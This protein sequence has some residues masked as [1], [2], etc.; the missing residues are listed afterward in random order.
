[1]A[2][3]ECTNVSDAN[4]C[5]RRYANDVSGQVNP[6]ESY[7][8][9]R[10]KWIAIANA[11]GKSESHAKS[12]FTKKK[13]ITKYKEETKKD[14]F[15]KKTVVKTP[16][17]YDYEYTFPW[18]LACAEFNAEIPEEAYIKRVTFRAKMRVTNKDAKVSKPIGNF[19]FRRFQTVEIKEETGG[20]KTGWHNGSYYVVDTNEKL[21]HTW[22]EHT[23][24]INEEDLQLAKITHENINSVFC[25]IDFI[26][27]KAEFNGDNGETEVR[28][29][30]IRMKVEY[31]MPNYE[32]GVYD[33]VHKVHENTDKTPTKIQ[34]DKQFIVYIFAHNRTKAKG[35]TQKVKVD[36]PW[37][38]EIDGVATNWG[39]FDPVTNIWTF[40]K[41]IDNGNNDTN[42]SLTFRLRSKKIGLSNLSAQYQSNG[43]GIN[44]WWDIDTTIRNSAYTQTT[45]TAVNTKDGFRRNSTCCVKVDIHVVSSDN[46]IDVH[47]ASTPY[48]QNTGTWSLDP[49]NSSPEVELTG[50]DD[51][52]SLN[53]AHLVYNGDPVESDVYEYN[54]SL[55]FCF[56]PNFVG[57]LTL[58]VMNSEEFETTYAYFDVLEALPF[59]VE[60][61]RI[62][63]VYKINNHRLFSEVEI[64][65]TIIRCVSD[66]IDK[67]MIMSNCS[68]SA[69]IWEDLD[70]IGCIPLEHLHFDPK[71]TYK[72]TL[73]NSTYKNKRYMGKKLA[74]DEDITL[75]VRLHPQQVT[76]LQGLIDMDKPIP[77]N[78]NHKCFEGDSLNH[79]GWAEVYAVKTEQTG[80][81]PHWYKCDIDVK[82]LTHN[83]NTRFKIDKSAKV[84]DYDS[85]I[86]S[87]MTESWSSGSNLS[88]DM[89]DSLG[90]ADT[91]KIPNNEA[92]FETDTDGTFHYVD[93]FYIDDELV[94]IDDD[95]RNNFN[96]DNGQH[97]RVTT[98]NPLTHISDVSFTWSS[99]LIDEIKENDISRIIRLKDKDNKVYF[100]YQYDNIIID[101][102]EISA[103]IIY[104]V[105]EEND[106]MMDYEPSNRMRFRY[107]PTDS[108]HEDDDIE[109]EPDDEAIDETGEAH[110]G[111][112]VELSLKNN[113][114][115][116]VDKG[117][118]GREVTISAELTDAEYYYEVEWVNNN[119]DAET[120][121]IECSFDFTVKDTILTSTYASKF[122][123]LVV[124]PYPI[125]GKK[126][127][128][129][130]EAQEGTI[131]YYED[132]RKEFSYLIEPY[133]QY[134]N[135]TDLVTNDGVS[136][137][138]LNYGY[139]IVYIQNGLVRLGFNRLNGELYLGKYDPQTDDYITT[140][141]L[142]LDKFDDINLN[143]ISD[144]KIEIQSSDSTFTIYRGHPYIK[145]KH[146]TEDIW[147]DTV[148]SRVWADGLD[149]MS[150]DTP[151]YWKLLNDK[152]LLPL[153]VTDKIDSDCIETEYVTHNDRQ[154]TSLS[155][156]NFPD[157]IDLGETT[158][159]LDS[160]Q[161][162][163]YSDEI[164]L[165]DTSCSFGEYTIE[166]E[167][168]GVVTSFDNFTLSKDIIQTNEQ[169]SLVARVTDALGKPVKGKT[170]YFYEWYNPYN[171]N[172][173]ATKNP[174][175]TGETTTLKARL[176][177][178]DGSGIKDSRVYFYEILDADY[179]N[180]GTTLSGIVTP[181]NASST[182]SDG[183]IKYTT[184]TSG[185]KNIYYNVPLTD[186]D[187][188]EFECEIAKIGVSQSIAMYIKNSTTSTG[189]WFSYEDSTGKFGGGC[190]GSSFGNVDLGALAVGDK[191]KI[192]R[193]DGV[194][195]IYKNNSLIYSK[196]TTFGSTY[197]IGHYTNNGREQYVKNIKIKK[198]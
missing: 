74:T 136:I 52:P 152:N 58:Q 164:S 158:F 71:S 1:M 184:S 84:S 43:K 49:D 85:T 87:V 114:L 138:N 26:W 128:F 131:Y 153:C 14:K 10:N 28:V 169:T 115:E 80:N 190:T 39:E 149:D 113:T 53:T 34:S 79:R 180:D 81:N 30:W 33:S 38:T 89:D 55:R 11:V 22:K 187:N 8:K 177:D 21:S 172:L 116:L 183:A 64:N 77:I 139:Q 107:N 62:P 140:H 198:Y 19:R 104:R 70:Y 159:K 168:D 120:S 9:Y 157:V 134:L 15:G 4:T 146:E 16:I 88:L 185:E 178:T 20:K 100:E 118:N 51:N 31:D 129:T 111:S 73:L 50:V 98:R 2:K 127:V 32:L 103:D 56:K 27:D 18:S 25:G 133:Y 40:P 122:S 124:S 109:L 137:F 82:Y 44:Y 130:R 161:L 189:C 191:I 92:Y 68:L 181:S 165:D 7:A 54:V 166:F 57:Q 142:H 176:K 163:G 12:N 76:T 145:I 86:P 99:V 48:I 179:F 36:I 125:A 67:N 59:L 126:I 93:D 97:I 147:I 63:S 194:L 60:V 195:S 6:N 66:P 35:K 171:L 101:D 105:L 112:T 143:S 150:S 78:A 121:D 154:N 148:S 72:D 155:W 162:Q 110:Y 117:F 91:D 23:W 196:T 182:I 83:L 3:V 13:I 94:K 192:K 132:D 41:F 123:K 173:N 17:A 61:N 108:T 188:F 197:Y 186:S 95:V 102:D 46:T 170:I 45:V 65:E 167:S 47:T 156:V 160:A 29:Q 141:N 135:G 69:D 175:Q 37:G 106:T 24:S 5:L 90:L 144:D 193:I 42:H 119:D 151:S 174:L 75:N 96:I